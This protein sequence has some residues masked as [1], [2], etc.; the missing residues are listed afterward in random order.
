MLLKT[1]TVAAVTCTAL[2]GYA[3]NPSTQALPVKDSEI[4]LDGVLNEAVWQQAAKYG[5]F[6]RF[7]FPEIKAAEPTTFQ[8][9][10]SES[11]LYWAFDVT[12]KNIV[13]TVKTFDGGIYR[14]DAIEMFITG[15]DPIPDD[16]NVHTAR[17]LIFSPDAVRSDITH[18]SGVSDRKWTSDWQVATKRTAKGYTAEVFIPYYALN[19]VNTHNKNFNFN[20]ARHNIGGNI[21]EY[22]VFSPTGRFTDQNKFA[23]LVL[24]FNDFTRYQWKT[25][26]MELKTVPAA[27][28]STRQVLNGS[29]TGKTQG[30]VILQATA[31]KAGKIAAFSRLKLNATADKT[32]NFT[33]PLAVGA[34]G[35]YDITLTARVGK[36]KV[37]YTTAGLTMEAVPFKLVVNNPFYRKSIFPDQLDKVISISIDYQTDASNLKGVKTALTVTNQANKVIAQAEKTSGALRTFTVDAADWQ[38]G[39]YTFTV[40]SSGSEALKG[41][42][43]ETFTVVEPHKKGNTVHLGKAREVFLNGKRFFPRGFLAANNHQPVFYKEMAEAGYNTVH[44]YTLN[45]RDLKG[46]KAILDEAHKHKLKVFF[47][48]Y[49]GTSIGFNG[50]QDRVVKVKKPYKPQLSPEAWERMKEMVNAVKEHPAFL[51]WYLADEPKG[52]EFCAELRNVYK[53]LRELDPHH[54]VIHL[55]FTAEGCINKREGYAD[56]HI[57]D[58]YPHPLVDGSWQRSISSVLYS[59]K[60]VNETVAPYGTWFCPEAFKPRSKKN[61]SL[62]YKEIRCLVFGTIVHGATGMVP[63]KI[64]DP[65]EKYYRP[66]R[67]SGIFISPEMHLGYLKGIGPE[68]NAMENVLLEPEKLPISTS[69]NYIVAMRKKHNNKEFIIAVNSMPDTLKCNIGGKNLPDGTYRVLGENRTVTVK[70]GKFSDTFTNYATHIYTNDANYSNGV[71]IAA[72]E[73]EIKKA[74]EAA[75]E[76]IKGMSWEELNNTAGKPAKKSKK[77]KKSKKK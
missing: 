41:T 27:K 40:K 2:L 77:S 50:F 75:L 29:L 17:Q 10:A 49:F 11:G 31:R 19:I 53:F 20:I 21:N 37:L 39:K 4:K 55:D 72:L 70:N 6:T 13:S 7:K 51:A 58:M 65:Q 28:G 46:V 32:M 42:L 12:D 67:N 35:K 73:A 22:S 48:P 71:D 76:E 26:P 61:R 66:I 68:L 44:F 3:A 18:L 59:M 69:S 36:E 45:Q 63:Y 47:Y 9:A 62:T 24:P 34:S 30:T 8:V 74:D 64:G 43:Q 25:G 1:L 15:D 14:D 5:N 57:L 38:P 33:M 52:E 60:L 56:L 54:P 16:P 23:A